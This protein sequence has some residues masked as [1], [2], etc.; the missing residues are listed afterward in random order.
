MAEKSKIRLRFTDN[1]EI[2]R[3]LNR[4]A[5]MVVNNELDPQRASAIATL[6]NTM[7]KAEKQLDKYLNALQNAN[8]EDEIKSTYKTLQKY[9]K[10]KAIFISFGILDD[11]VVLNGRLDGELI[12]NDFNVYRGINTIKI[13]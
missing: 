3:S 8:S 11:Y 4:V 1:R 13:K 5:N 6:C 2:K 9:V 7:L 10:E 12:C